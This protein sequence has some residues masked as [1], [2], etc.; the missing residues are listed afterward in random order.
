[1]RA[2]PVRKVSGIGKVSERLLQVV[3][4]KTCG[5][6]FDQRYLIW[7]LFTRIMALN[8]LR[9]SMGLGS[10]EMNTEEL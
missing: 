2:L 3:D 6:L 7:Q 5:D 9:L 8:F 4:V 1:M 10:S